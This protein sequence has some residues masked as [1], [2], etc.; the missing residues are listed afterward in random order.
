MSSVFERPMHEQL[1][2][3]R[4]LTTEN[5]LGDVLAADT[6]TVSNLIISVNRLANFYGTS[7]NSNSIWDFMVPNK[8]K[9]TLKRSR[10]ER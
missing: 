8:T 10:D 5:H 9:P 7:T 3:W 2:S 1:S 4:G 6:A